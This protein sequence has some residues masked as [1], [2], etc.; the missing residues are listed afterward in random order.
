MKEV[1]VFF[2]KEASNNNLDLC[3]KKNNYLPENKGTEIVDLYQ[4]CFENFL[5]TNELRPSDNDLYIKTSTTG[6][7]LVTEG[8]QNN[9]S[10]LE[11]LKLLNNPFFLKNIFTQLGFNSIEPLPIVNA[12]GNTL[13]V[14]A[15]VQIIDD[16]IHNDGIITEKPKFV[17]QPVLRTQYIDGVSEGSSTS[18]INISTEAV[19][20]DPKEHFCFLQQWLK[21]F[22]DLG[23]EKDKFTFK[24][25]HIDKTWG[26]KTFNGFELFIYYDGLEIGDGSFNYNV[27]QNTRGDINFSDIGFGLERVKWILSGGSYFDTFTTVYKNQLTLPSLAY[28]N[29]LS[30]LSGSGLKPSNKEYGYRFRLFSKRFV[31][32]VKGK[33][34]ELDNLFNENYKYW[35][36]WTKL[37]ISESESLSIIR[38][39]NSRNFN[40][41]LLDELLKKFN[42]VNLDINLPT[43]EIIKRLSHT[44]VDTKT[45]E[46]TINNL[47][48]KK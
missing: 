48:Y 23:M 22:I 17:I 5:E 18:F 8:E 6:C 31:D 7:N 40:R 45:L 42:D 33:C 4:V 34:F 41:L 37:Q 10:N 21:I 16:I 15:G 32:E 30:L 1:C 27:A 20:I 28:A 47:N 35:S 43:N 46:E 19:N 11:T 29:T 36:N 2:V 39:E 3:G 44:S 12:K 13:F 26:N 9:K 38:K 14:S 24:S 25:R